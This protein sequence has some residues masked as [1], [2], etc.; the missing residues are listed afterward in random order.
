M[1][2][3]LGWIKSNLVSVIFF[4]LMV[5]AVVA[6]PLLSRWLNTGVQEAMTERVSRYRE[7]EK[8]EKT[9]VT[10]SSPA[11]G[12]AV[13]GT[14]LVNEKLLER[15]RAVSEAE[16]ADATEVRT[17]ALEHNRKGRGVILPR[18]F[19]EPP[20]AEREVLPERFHRQ[21]EDAYAELLERVNAGGPPSPE[22]VAED[23]ERHR[24]QYLSQILAKEVTDTLEP[25]EAEQLRDVLRK[26]RMS[27]YAAQAEGLGMYADMTA[28]NV[29]IWQQAR[30]PT[31]MEL[32][33]WQWEYWII[34]D[35]LLALSEAN[36]EQSVQRAPVK[37]VI[38][39]LPF[40]DIVAA[41][42]GEA[43]GGA[44]SGGGSPGM[45]GGSRRG[46]GDETAAPKAKAANPS[47][48]VKLDFSRSFTGRYS[49]PLYD[50]R[51]VEVQ[52]VVETARLTDVLDALARRNF[53]TVID[54]KLTPADHYSAA[55]DGFFYGSEPI[56]NVTLTVETVWLREWTAEFMPAAVR[57]AL[58]VADPKPAAGG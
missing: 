26:Q 27:L 42:G 25:D 28:L 51:W 21:L 1:S 50:V 29:P 6:L 24:A 18:L 53:M 30:Q 49:N 48:E 14:V 23:L 19:P 34:E 9:D 13:S 36:G 39:V 33:Q 22:S 12:E 58:G 31:P 15:Y 56:S 46:G 57:Q 17:L 32:F 16:A 44:P 37:R 55:R 45:G 43:S 8:L 38:S 4:V 20:P 3:V 10:V 54:V 5:A 47:Q 2:A 52:L 7:L 40:D 35:I 41:G 11:G